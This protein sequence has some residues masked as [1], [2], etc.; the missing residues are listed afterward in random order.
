M[1]N[2]SDDVKLNVV[3]ASDDDRVTN[4]RRR[5][6]WTVEELKQL[7]AAFGSCIRTKTMPSGKQITDL[8][9]KMPGHTVAQIRTQINNLILGKRHMLP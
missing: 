2:Y 8:S 7:S 5:R 4:K 9:K 3:D 6:R 1:S